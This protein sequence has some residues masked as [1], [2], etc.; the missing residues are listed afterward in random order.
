MDLHA[1]DSLSPLRWKIISWKLGGR[2]E[3][4][5]LNIKGLWHPYGITHFREVL[6][7]TPYFMKEKVLRTR[8]DISFATISKFYHWKTG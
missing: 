2:Q 7:F 8:V 4:Y 3:G 6:D 5:I 1:G